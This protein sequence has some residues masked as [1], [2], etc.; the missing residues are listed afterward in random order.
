[1]AQ[2]KLRTQHFRWFQNL[3]T[4][5]IHRPSFQ[6]FFFL[7]DLKKT[8]FFFIQKFYSVNVSYVTFY[9]LQPR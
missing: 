6:Q 1:M 9:Y 7:L 4:L 3:F 5:V 2:L 8:D